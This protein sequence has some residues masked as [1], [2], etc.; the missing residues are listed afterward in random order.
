M[1]QNN[2]FEQYIEEMIQ[3]EIVVEQEAFYN[4]L[5]PIQKAERSIINSLSESLAK[6]IDREIL[7]N[8]KGM[9]GSVPIEHGAD[10]QFEFGDIVNGVLQINATIR[11]T[12]EYITCNFTLENPSA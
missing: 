3:R 6:E 5:S 2:F 11:P 8:L 4:N 1:D 12:V 7:E 9:A 10:V